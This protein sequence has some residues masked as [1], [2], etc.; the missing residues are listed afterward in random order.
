MSIQ[1]PT[2]TMMNGI[3]EEIAVESPQT[4][5]QPGV[6][7]ELVGDAAVVDTIAIGALLAGADPSALAT[8]AIPT[9]DGQSATREAGIPVPALPIPTPKIP[10]PFPRRLSSGRYRSAGAGFQLELRVDVDGVRPTMRVSGD[11]FQAIGLTV[12]YFGSFIVDAVSVTTTPTTRTIEGLGSFTF[13]AGAPRVRVTIPRVPILWPAPSATVQFF[14]TGGAP[15]ATYVCRYQSAYMRTVR[16]DQDITDDAIGPAFTSY[17]TGSLPSGGPARV[18]TVQK[19]YAEAGVEMLVGGA[20]DVV[21]VVEATGDGNLTWSNSELHASM[22]K[23]FEIYKHQPQ[24]TLWQLVAKDHEYGPGLYGIMFDSGERFGSAVFTRGIGGTTADQ[25]RLQLYTYVHEMGHSFNLMHSW[26]KSLANPPKVNRPSALSWMNYPWYYPGGPAAFWAAFPFQFDNPELIHIRHGFRNNVIQGGNPFTIGAS[27]FE[28]MG[29]ADPIEDNSGLQL[30]IETK[31]AY[32]FGEPVVAEMKLYVND[33][34]GKEVHS[35]LDPAT[36]LVQI[37]IK[38]PAGEVKLYEPL[39]EECV[40]PQTTL[41]DSQNPSIY[42]STYI[43]YGK[44]GFYF[45]Q[46][47]AYTVRAIYYAL[48]GSQVLSNTTTLRVR[49]P[50]TAQ[51]EDAAELLLGDQQGTLLAL[52]GSDAPQL[53]AGNDALETLLVDYP[54]HPLTTYARLAKGINYGRTFKTVDAKKVDP[55]TKKLDIRSAKPA[56]SVGLL[57]DV[58]AASQKGGGV[59]NITLNMTMRRIARAQKKEGDNRAA[60]ETLDRMVNLFKNKRLKPHVLA[61]I[62]EQAAEERA[63]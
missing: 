7:E 3:V 28:P 53:R 34:R 46:P 5:E 61:R 12:N 52:L 6:S 42:K 16:R 36:G 15:G 2:A 55:M 63:A 18:L 44:D 9:E 41:L 45:D 39:I 26:Q 49:H 20:P 25:E 60:N 43:G 17:N 47:G 23:H 30:E 48:D 59:D 58:V 29:F 24:W 19:A 33:M 21:P 57:S 40:G 38:N 35:H 32:V 31:P 8:E 56:D 13:H 1:D 27:L 50:H 10:F 22:L 4:A 62:E 11:F 37:A 54:K 14:T 51:D